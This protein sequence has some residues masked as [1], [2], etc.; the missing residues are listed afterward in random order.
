MGLE[1]DPCPA[2]DSGTAGFLQSVVQRWT[3][4]G[5][6][7]RG[8]GSHRRE[9]RGRCNLCVSSKRPEAS[10]PELWRRFARHWSRCNLAYELRRRNDFT[11]RGTRRLASLQAHSACLTVGRH[12]ALKVFGENRPK[13]ARSVH[14]RGSLR[15]PSTPFMSLGRRVA[16]SENDSSSCA[17]QLRI[18]PA[19]RRWT[20]SANPGATEKRV[21]PGPACTETA[22]QF[23]PVLSAAVRLGSPAR[24]RQ[25]TTAGREMSPAGRHARAALGSAGYTD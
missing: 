9:C 25:R 10:I 19:S 6:S 24:I 17:P 11:Y 13:S 16:V 3:D 15:N 22:G 21:W 20:H 14:F 1:W 2:E 5:D 12:G 23:Y 8:R 4:L 7:R 18:D